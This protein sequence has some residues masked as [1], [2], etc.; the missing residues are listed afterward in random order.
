ME[1]KEG[2]SSGFVYETRNVW[3]GVFWLVAAIAPIGFL[4]LFVFDD[5]L[6]APWWEDP[7]LLIL[8]GAAIVFAAG[9]VFLGVAQ[10]ARCRRLE[11]DPRRRTVE[12]SERGLFR[13]RSISCNWD[14]AT[15][16]VRPTKLYRGARESDWH[17]WTLFV[18][19]PDGRF[20]LARTNDRERM[21]EIVR[22]MAEKLGLPQA[23]EGEPV[24]YHVGYVGQSE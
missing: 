8:A 24:S 23:P 17:G 19:L 18:E 1:P 20:S 7:E 14:E 10:I 9:F 11:L 3:G 2:Y 22:N 5:T 21:D 4:V 12:L 6:N 15:L 16:Q 13:Q